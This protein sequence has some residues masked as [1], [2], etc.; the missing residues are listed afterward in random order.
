MSRKDIPRRDEVAGRWD[1]RARQE[2]DGSRATAQDRQVLL[3]RARGGGRVP[4]RVR[5]IIHRDASYPEQSHAR[6]ELW[7]EGGWREIAFLLGRLV[8]NDAEGDLKAL[9]DEVLA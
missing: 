4:E 6:A 2:V 7:T 5:L 8:A 3:H 1:E 9:V